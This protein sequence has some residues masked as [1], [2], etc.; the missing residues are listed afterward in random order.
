MRAFALAAAVATGIVAVYPTI[1]RTVDRTLYSTSS[2]HR[3][4]ADLNESGITQAIEH[5]K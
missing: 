1:I 5:E 4:V 3:V 2:P